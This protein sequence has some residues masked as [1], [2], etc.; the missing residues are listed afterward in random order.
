[1]VYLTYDRIVP[2]TLKISGGLGGAHG[3]GG[4]SGGVDGTDGAPGADGVK[5]RYNAS[6]KQWE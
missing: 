5:L 6:R 1:V 2:G 4:G 3:N